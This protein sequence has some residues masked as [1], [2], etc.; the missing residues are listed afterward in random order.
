MASGHDQPHFVTPDSLD[1]AG[2]RVVWFQW[3]TSPHDILAP[4]HSDSHESQVA[5]KPG[6]DDKPVVAHIVLVCYSYTR[7]PH[8]SGAVSAS[9]SSQPWMW[10]WN[11]VQDMSMHSF[12]LD[13][14]LDMHQHHASDGG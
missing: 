2:V 13:A 1:A 5:P 4:Q 9:S 12:A 8:S 3:M 11:P 6:P 7:F 10:A 14:P